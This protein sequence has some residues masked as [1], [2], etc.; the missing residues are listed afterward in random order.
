MPDWDRLRQGEF[1]VLGRAGMDLYPDPPGTP[2]AEAARF[3]SDLGGSAGN[4][5]AA[6]VRAG[7]RAALVSAVSDDAVGRF[8]LAALARHGIGHA[9]VALRGG[10][11]RTSLALAESRIAGHETVI[12]RNNAAD[13]ALTPLDVAALPY[14]DAAA[15]VVT[16]TALAA[17]PSRSATRA[18]MATAAKAGCPVVLDLDYRPY[19]W[20][21][22]AEAR[23]IMQAAADAADMIVGNDAEFGVL[24]GVT[25]AGRD[26]ARDLARAMGRNGRIAV[27]KMGG[28][29]SV[30]F[31]DDAET[32]TPVF[33][34]TPLKPFGA[35]D[36]FL[37]NLLAGL[38][39]G[40]NLDTSLRRGSA[41][42]AMVV[43]TVGCAGAMPTPDALD[44]FIARYPA[45][46]RS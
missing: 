13:F 40:A 34:V 33:P 6:L 16:G 10:G 14:A 3:V 37:G 32:E 31:S 11:V 29:G 18:A 44:A 43:A 24:A 9:H 5:A 12:Y 8:V 17:E 23:T 39:G 22:S 38:A 7:R 4:I 21:D 25:A 35:G 41:A 2:T 36:A 28:A 1:L 46:Q 19:G 42:A 30:T 15:L 20:A 26:L 27:Y 45:L